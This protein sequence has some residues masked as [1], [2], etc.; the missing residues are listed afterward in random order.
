MA[1]STN[2][3]WIIDADEKRNES[4]AR[5]L[6]GWKE[7]SVHWLKCQIMTGRISIGHITLPWLQYRLNVTFDDGRQYYSNVVTIECETLPRP[8]L[9]AT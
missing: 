2:S 5:S 8:K 4:I 1:T 7:L 6:Y 3:S 9:T